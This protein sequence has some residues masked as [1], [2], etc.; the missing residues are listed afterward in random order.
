MKKFKFTLQTVHNVREMKQER[1]EMTLAEII[2]EVNRAT[3]RIAQIEKM[4]LEAV[5]KYTQRLRA[6]EVLNATEMELNAKYF[7]SLDGLQREA[8]K[9]LSEK[10]LACTAQRVKLAGAAREVKI[11][12]RLR[13]HQYLRH[14][15]EAD[16]QQQINLD[17]IVSAGYA[18]KMRNKL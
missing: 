16:K 1:E 12:D 17:E 11:T 6:G 8:E 4:R 2:M 13:E 9:L 5:E 15:L 14:Q 18:R 3:E 10:N 7:N